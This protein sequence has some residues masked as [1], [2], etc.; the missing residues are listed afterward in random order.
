[1][2]RFDSSVVVDENGVPLAGAIGQ[3]YDI[4]DTSHTTPLALFDVAGAPL[5]LDQLKANDDGVTPQFTTSTPRV[6]WVSGPY[7]IDMLAWDI[8]PLGGATGQT[9]VKNSDT[10]FDVEWGAAPN[11]LPGGGSI[12]QVLVKASALDG[13]VDWVDNMVNVKAFGAVGD[14]TTDDRSA[15]QA[16]CDQGGFIYF[17]PGDY[18]SSGPI[19]VKLDGTTLFGSGAGNRNG[20][21]QPNPGTRIRAMTGA[22]GS[23]IRVQR[24]ADDRPLANVQIMNMTIDG[25]NRAGAIDGIVFRASQSFMVN[26]NI[27]QCTGVGLRVQGYASPYWDTY[28]TRFTNML[29]GY[30]GVAGALLDNNAADLHFAHC[31][32][33]YNFDNM[34]ITGGSSQQVTGCHFYSG[35]RY[36]LFINGAGSRSKFANCKFE[37]NNEHCV[38]IDSTNGGYSDIQFTGNGFSTVDQSSPTNTFDLVHIT[39]PSSN[40]IGRTTFVGN[41]FGLKGG[42]SV[43]NR[44][45]INLNGSAVQ[46]TVIVGNSFGPASHWG[47]APLNNAGSTSLPAFVRNN[48]NLPDLILPIVK[49]ASF[50]VSPAE[51]D[52]SVVEMNSSSAT[53]VTIPPNAQP[54]FMKGNTLTFTQTGTGQVTFAAGSGVTLRTPRSLTTRA[55]WSTVTL[56]QTAS[57]VWILEGDMT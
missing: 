24:A 55:Q 20:A 36:N 8:I 43:K 47:T 50:T 37:G 53:V 17:P 32:F 27:W 39:G 19:Q 42:S 1:M 23:I 33:L 56:R 11:G 48:L 21:S 49:T 25:D 29:I 45:A 13:V 12:G 54:G 14:G 7:E 51:A 41:N 2:S 6:T 30:C 52:G 34:V 44:F 57:N 31:V 15:I 9:L 4:N 38:L 18:R 5:T 40:G 35:T 26:V 28:D 3:V 46:N 22:S 16:A 10:D